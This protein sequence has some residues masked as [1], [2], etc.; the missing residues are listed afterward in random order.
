MG[1][2]KKEESNRADKFAKISIYINR[3]SM[4]LCYYLLL[5]C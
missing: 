5:D 2:K 1:F 3:A 4:F